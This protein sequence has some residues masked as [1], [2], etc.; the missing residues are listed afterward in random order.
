MKKEG[1][2]PQERMLKRSDFLECFAKGRKKSS[3]NFIIFYQVR[4]VDY[5]RIGIT[6]S[7]KVG[8]AVRRNRM[9]RLLREFFRLHKAFFLP[10]LDYS[11]VVKKRCSLNTLNDVVRELIPLLLRVRKSGNFK[12]KVSTC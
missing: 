4:R 12:Q 1:F 6:V 9:K 7:K 11:I 10:G 2:S 3:A 8:N 5:P